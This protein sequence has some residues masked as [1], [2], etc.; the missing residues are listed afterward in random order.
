MGRPPPRLWGISR[1][2]PVVVFYR[3]APAPNARNPA[4]RGDLLDPAAAHPLHGYQLTE[5]DDDVWRRL[6]LVHTGDLSVEAFE[7]WVY[8]HP[9]M[10]AVL[11]SELA[12]DFL[13]FDY[14]QPDAHHE[15]R[16]LVERAYLPRGSKQLE[17][18]M[19]RRVA[20]EFLSGERDVWRTAAPFAH[21]I[22]SGEYD[23]IPM[24][25]LYVDSELDAIPSPAARSRWQ[26]AALAKLLKKNGVLLAGYE[27]AVREAVAVLLERIE[28]RATGKRISDADL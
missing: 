3:V 12:A 18:D 22:A 20:N 21:L 5:F 17:Y 4:E 19:M 2:R 11:G 28:A 26:P 14:R 13:A 27:F 23:W 8:A 16:K 15:L 25:F 1:F 10:E 9:G 24:G 6:E 7:Q